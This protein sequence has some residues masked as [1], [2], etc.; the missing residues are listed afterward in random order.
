MN[1]TYRHVSNCSLFFDCLSVEE[2]RLRVTSKARLRGSSSGPPKIA[3]LS[4]S[5]VVGVMFN[6]SEA[7]TPRG[8]LEDLRY[9]DVPEI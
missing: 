4:S 1:H 9:G 3:I 2:D 7:I 6:K 5:Q 8:C